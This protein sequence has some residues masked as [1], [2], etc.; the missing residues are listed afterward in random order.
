MIRQA[1]S[2][3]AGCKRCEA[4]RAVHSV[5]PLPILFFFSRPSCLKLQTSVVWD[6]LNTGFFQWVSSDISQEPRKIPRR[7]ILSA[8]LPER[9]QEARKNPLSIRAFRRDCTL[10][11][12]RFR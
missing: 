8:I 11:L 10:F 9:R 7:Y 2:R 12:I 3:H 1:R 5:N 6:F 4:I